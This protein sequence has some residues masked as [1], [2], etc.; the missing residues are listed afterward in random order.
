MYT[1]LILFSFTLFPC[2]TLAQSIASKYSYDNGI[3]NDPSV[4]FEA[5]FEGASV[6]AAVTPFTASGYAR[7]TQFMQLQAD[8]PYTQTGQKSMQL[9]GTDQTDLFRNL[10]QNY[11][12]LYL[13][14]YIKYIDSVG[15][16][17]SGGTIGGQSTPS[18]FIS[19][20]PTGRPPTGRYFVHLEPSV[21]TGILDSYAYLQNM[22]P[23]YWGV[24]LFRAK[25]SAFVTNQWIC[26][27]IMVKVNSTATS[28]DGEMAFWRNGVLISHVKQ[29]SPK[30]S[31]QNNVLVESPTAPP[32]EGLR[33]R[34]T[35]NFANNFI[36]INNYVDLTNN[37]YARYRVDNIV[38]AT[39][40]IGPINTGAVSTQLKKPERPVLVK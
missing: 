4:V 38:V 36:W 28:K 21:S 10:G 31:F 37:N 24:S 25:N 16:H 12:E 18:N 40:Y 2:L 15:Y 14:Y 6:A 20:E 39:K 1:L 5:N 32:F 27:E 3:A 35:T 29:G 11:N 8:T 23:V 19:F 33:W 9:G 13:R 34:D 7:N 30:G 17:H 26:I 22:D